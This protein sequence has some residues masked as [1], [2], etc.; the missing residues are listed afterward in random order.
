MSKPTSTDG[1]QPPGIAMRVVSTLGTLAVLPLLLPSA[2]AQP[3]V[4][5]GVEVLTTL[6]EE[7]PLDSFG[8]VAEALGDLDGDLRPDYIIGAPG[9]PG[10]AFS[11][12]V[13]VYSGASGE[14][15][16]AIEGNPGDGLGFSVVGLGDVNGDGVPDYA[17]GGP[18]ADGVQAFGRLLI[19]SGAT[20]EILI[21]LNGVPG[22]VFAYDIN[23]AGDLNGDG[24][25]DVI[26]GAIGGGSGGEGEVAIVSGADGAI[27]WQVQGE[28][29]GDNFGSGVS[30]L[31]ADISGDG[32]PDQVVGALAGG[33]SNT[34][35]AYLLSGA[36]GS[37][38]FELEGLETAGSLG[39]FFAHRAGDVNA[40]GVV[41]AYVGDF[42]DSALGGLDGRAYVFSGADGTRL[43]VYDAE[44]AND[45]FGIGRTV[46]DIDGDGHS[47][48]FLAA[49]TH[50]V[51]AVVQGGKGYLYSGRDQ[52]LIRSMTGSVSGDQLGFDAL[53]VGDLDADGFAELMLTGVGVVHVVRGTDPSPAARVASVC[54]LLA[55]F[56]DEAYLEPAAPRKERLCA[57]LTQV[58]G[59]VDAQR[60]LLANA[61]LRN[62]VLPRV[63][64][65]VGE[66][67][68]QD[69]LLDPVLQGIALPWVEGLITLTQSL[70]EDNLP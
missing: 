16:N 12:K 40:D 47:D 70:A 64:G 20:H 9:F 8:F 65:V 34:G 11:G 62:R 53:P 48:L 6:F 1:A 23:L 39:W 14:L 27:L 55:G 67:L 29:S 19:V 24:V 54:D 38:L 41:D 36:D 49:Y 31:G 57:L 37:T 51:G 2:A 15:L 7:N 56:P 4:E 21:D 46:G 42:S 44:F 22:S 13:Y 26:V 25:D 35:L 68:A 66:D 3:F 45:G 58:R 69:W 32:I 61:R 17:T 5:P 33:D 59:L 50:S 52:S 63:D 28:V 10:G 60:Y 30:G 18:F 43:Q